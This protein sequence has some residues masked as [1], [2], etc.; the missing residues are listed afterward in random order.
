MNHMAPKSCAGNLRLWT[1]E[2][3]AMASSIILL[4]AMTVLLAAF[5][6]KPIF[7]NRIWTLN[8]LISTLSTASKAS[9]LAAVASCISQENWVLFSGKP[10]RLYDFELVS[11]ASR[12]PFGSFKVLTSLSLRGG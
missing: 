1:P 11:G 2:I 9:L 5:N 10:R 12:G 3:L 6:R 7:D 4:I 8:A